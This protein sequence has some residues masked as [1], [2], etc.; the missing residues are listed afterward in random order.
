MD[1]PSSRRKGQCLVRFYGC[2]GCHEIAGWKTNSASAPSSPRKAPS[3]SS[4]LI[5]PCSGHKAERRRLVHHKGFFEHKL[6]E[7]RRLR[8]GQGESPSR[9]ACA[10]RTSTCQ[11]GNRRR[12]H[13]PDGLGGSPGAGALLLHAG[14][15]A[16]GHHRWLVGGAQVQLH[17]LPPVHVGQT[18]CHDPGALSGSRVER[19][20]AAHAHRRRRAR[21]SGLDDE[22]PQQSGA[23]AKPD[24]DRNGVRPYL[25][26]RMPTFFFSDGEIRK[27]VRFFEALS[28]QAD[29]LHSARS[30]NRY[31]RPGKRHGAAAFTSE[32]APCLK[33]HCHGRP[34]A[35]Q[36]RHRAEFPA[37]AGPAEARMGAALDARPGHDQPRH[38][39]AFRP[40]PA[41]RRPVGLR[42]SHAASFNGYEGPCRLLVRYM[43]EFT[44]EELSR[45]RASAGN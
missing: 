4:T 13:V 5:S 18:T 6:A 19:S 3:P 33:C 17:G 29:A 45:L 42:R 24:T 2:A 10:C 31:Q 40:V 9:T 43:F 34:H 30:S 20:V 22:L 8:S 26:V 37:G 12:H 27:L 32:G 14:R 41:G 39:H 7:A 36:V 1:D 11:A 38:R 35:R 23:D 25:Q 15:P 21:Q 16:A 44:P 28:A